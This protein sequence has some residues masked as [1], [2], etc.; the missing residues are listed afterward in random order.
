MLVT[1]QWNKSCSQ[2]K[3][4][5]LTALDKNKLLFGLHSAPTSG[6]CLIESEGYADRTEFLQ[7]KNAGMLY[8]SNMISVIFSRF[9]LVF[10]WN[11]D[12]SG[13]VMKHRLPW[14]RHAAQIEV[15]PS[16]NNINHPVE[17]LPISRDTTPQ[18]QSMASP[19]QSSWHTSMWPSK[20]QYTIQG[21]ELR[22]NS[23]KWQIWLNGDEEQTVS[24]N[25][26]KQS[27]GAVCL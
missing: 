11:T 15:T 18:Q 23:C 14:F 24:C 3:C 2:I 25:S 9:A 19:Q 16:W 27:N 17:A 26:N 22:S 12:W 5:D 6:D 4:Y 21:N 1:S 20:S 13:S 10:H 8:F 7:R